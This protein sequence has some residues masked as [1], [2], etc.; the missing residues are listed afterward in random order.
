MFVGL[1]LANMANQYN[2]LTVFFQGIANFGK[3]GLTGQFNP[4][5]SYMYAKIPGCSV[6]YISDIG[7]S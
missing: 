3:E 2:Q 4:V 6:I 7:C 1:S 5:Y